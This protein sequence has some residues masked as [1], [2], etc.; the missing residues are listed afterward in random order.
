[1]LSDLFL[2]RAEDVSELSVSDSPLFEGDSRVK[3]VELRGLTGLQLSLLWAEIDKRSH[4]RAHYDAQARSEP[5]YETVLEAFPP[6]ATQAF[7]KLSDEEIARISGGLGQ[8]ADFGGRW[9]EEGL[10]WLLSSI[11]DLTKRADGRVLCLWGSI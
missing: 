7:A 6:E 10:H 8:S 3:G 4:P 11:R 1:M 9:N 5:P 2:C